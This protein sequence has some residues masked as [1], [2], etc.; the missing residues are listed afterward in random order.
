MSGAVSFEV[1]LGNA[2]TP[3]DEADVGV[4]I[5]VTDVRLN[6]SLN[7]YTGQLLASITLRIT[8][9][10]SGPTATEVGTITDVP[11]N[12][13]IPCAATSTST[14]GATCSLSTTADAVLPGMVTEIKRTI[15]QIGDVRIFDGGPDG[16]ASTQDNT[17][18]LR[19][20]VFVP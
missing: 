20:G 10:L 9:R 11:F 15:W 19:Q 17:L 3:A 18:F 14:I 6:P 1:M 4:G 12:I 8:D 16:Q 5:S 13:T 7:D 2:A